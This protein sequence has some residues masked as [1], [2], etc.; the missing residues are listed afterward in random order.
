MIMRKHGFTLVEIVMVLVAIGILLVLVPLNLRWVENHVQ[1][2]LISQK[3]E[4][5]RDAVSIRMRQGRIYE[6]S[7]L[8][9]S[10]TWRDIAYTWGI[11]GERKD[12]VVFEKEIQITQQ[13]NTNEFAPLS[14]NDPLEWKMWSY[15][16]SCEGP[17]DLFKVSYQG[18]QAC[19]QVDLNSCILKRMKCNK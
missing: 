14:P 17:K 10:T 15:G 7:T 6:S 5:T 9:L 8:S 19:Y 4:D 12:V 18:M 16:I 3:I 1:L 11:Q 2:S 13:N